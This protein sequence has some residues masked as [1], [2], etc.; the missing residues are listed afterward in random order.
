[1]VLVELKGRAEGR[2]PFFSACVLILPSELCKLGLQLLKTAS[3][4]MQ[5][6][7]QNKTK[8]PP[9]TFLH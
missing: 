6:T 8:Q 5:K 4:L 7:K 2:K 3:V 1:M 9:R